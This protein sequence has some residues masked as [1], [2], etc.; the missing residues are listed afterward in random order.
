MYGQEAV[1]P[2]E[3]TVPSLLIA[4]SLHFSEE[5]SLRERLQELQELDEARFLAEF[6][7]RV[8]KDR[9]KAWH[10][11]HIKTKAFQVGGKVLLYNNRF[12]KFPRK[13]QM[14]WLGPYFVIEIRDSGAVQLAQ[15][16][17]TVLPGW[18]N[19]ARLKPYQE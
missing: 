19:G 15:L 2:T 3:F 11:R 10:D 17:G 16:D 4:T 5:A 9:Q 6:H 13:L 1:I 7:Q 14:H 18:V 12:Q 8:E